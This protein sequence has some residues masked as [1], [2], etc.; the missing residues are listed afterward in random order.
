MAIL[1]VLRNNNLSVCTLGWLTVY[2]L[3]LFILTYA[4]NIH[5]P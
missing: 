5:Q 3:L 2:D 4:S 1:N